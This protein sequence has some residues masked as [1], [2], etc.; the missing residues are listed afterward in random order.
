P[1]SPVVNALEVGG[2]MTDPD[3]VFPA[4]D[5]LRIPVEY[6][7]NLLSAGDTEVIRVVLK[8]LA[9]LRSYM[10]RKEVH[11]H[12]DSELA[13]SVGMAPADIEA[14]YRL[15]AIAKYED[16]YVIPQAHTELADRLMEQQGACGLDFDGGPGNC[17]AIASPSAPPKRADNSRFM[18]LQMAPP[19]TGQ[20]NGGQAAGEAERT[21]GVPASPGASGEG[22]EFRP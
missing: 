6:L 10:R 16:R 8:R 13:A 5:S 3:D 21:R 22:G 11:Q 18:L 20:G 19:A 9:T 4:I 1:L 15:L 17:G 7:A 12:T 2:P 14:L